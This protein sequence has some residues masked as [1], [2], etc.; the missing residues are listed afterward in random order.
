MSGAHD[1]SAT[2]A[3]TAQTQ[4]TTTTQPAA[5]TQT[6]AAA[7]PEWVSG[8]A[9]ELRAVVD[10]KG[11]KTPA[12]VVAAYANAERLI[13]T[14]KIPLPKDGVWDPTALEKLGVPKEPAGYQIKRPELP[15]GMTYDEG[16]EKAALPLLHKAGY[17][18]AQVQAAVDAF[19]AYQIQQNEAAAQER[20]R[21]ETET[22]QAL[23][24]EWGQKYD[25]NVALAQRAAK[26]YGGDAFVKL[27]NESGLGNNPDFIRTFAK[28]GETMKEDSLIAGQSS[29]FKLTPDQAR[30][31]ANKL[32]ATE[33]Y[34]KRDHVEHAATVDKV[35]RLFEAAYPDAA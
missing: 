33:A 20:T 7:A 28:V 26:H 12:D 1:A 21:V 6:P 16:L 31:E 14:D 34:T 4:T 2:P 24:G 10:A 25:G 29:G 17:T 22:T 27:L 30:A 11:Y 35:K 3:G 5:Q 15:A 8:L 9:P 18:P 13:G 19:S 23:R 32:M